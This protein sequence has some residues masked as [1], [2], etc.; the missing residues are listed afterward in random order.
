MHAQPKQK[1]ANQICKLQAATLLSRAIDRTMPPKKKKRNQRQGRGLQQGAGLLDVPMHLLTP[2]L[3][4]H[5]DAGSMLAVFQASR[6][7][8]DLVL[9]I[10]PS[11]KL[12]IAVDQHGRCLA[13]TAASAAA[14]ALQLCPHLHIILQHST[15]QHMQASS[16]PTKPAKQ[17]YPAATAAV[18]HV[19]A[20]PVGR[21]LTSLTLQVRA[22]DECPM[23]LMQNLCVST[24][25]Y[26]YVTH[27]SSI[28]QPGTHCIT[29]P[30][31]TCLP[32]AEHEV[33]AT[34]GVKSSQHQQAVPCPLFAKPCMCRVH[35]PVADFSSF[36]CIA[37]HHAPCRAWS[38][39]RSCLK[40]WLRR[41]RRCSA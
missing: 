22:M 37:T 5:L 24:H 17:R 25:A 13:P 26:N 40:Q 34:L 7:L 14:A 27:G 8:R 32:A 23:M 31:S 2:Y 18:Q 12:S 21:G 39:M 16:G 33:A 30:R 10:A 41:A 29:K 9:G 11:V 3:Q 6:A 35:A 38:W 36:M 15:L 20:P 19:L 4:Q 1:T 28:L